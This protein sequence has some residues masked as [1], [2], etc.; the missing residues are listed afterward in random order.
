VFAFVA[1]ALREGSSVPAENGHRNSGDL[2]AELHNKLHNSTDSRV[3]LL[4]QV[5]IS[6]YFMGI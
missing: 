2:S 1:I 6:Q 5:F 3:T 4:Q